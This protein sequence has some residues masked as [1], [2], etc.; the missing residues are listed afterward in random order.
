MEDL[1]TSLTTGLTSTGPNGWEYASVIIGALGAVCLWVLFTFVIKGGEKRTPAAEAKGFF[2]F[3]GNFALDLAMIVYWY[4]TL[5]TLIS[6]FE[7]LSA[8]YGFW[9]FIKV[10]VGQLI[11]YRFVYEIIKAVVK[12]NS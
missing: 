10:V 1:L 8:P 5:R 7:L 11:W 9:E 6:S 4:M 12:K 2:L 3:R